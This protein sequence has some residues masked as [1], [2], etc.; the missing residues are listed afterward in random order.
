MRATKLRVH[1]PFTG[2]A[3]NTGVILD[4]REHGPSRLEGGIVNDVIIIFYLQDRCPKLH[5]CSR[6]VCSR[7]VCRP[8]CL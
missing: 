7:V 4:T 3:V 8:T 1:G 2:R 6:A 5:P